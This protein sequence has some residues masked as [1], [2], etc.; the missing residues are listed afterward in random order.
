MT[1][2]LA[3]AAIWLNTVANALGR[4]LLAPVGAL[5][6]WLSAT[7]ASAGTGVLLLVLFKYTSNQQAIKR[8]RNDINAHM[9]ALKLFKDSALVSLKAQGRIL[10]GA[11]CLLV[12]AIVPILVMALPLTLLVAQLALWYQARPLRIGE[13]TIVALNLGGVPESPR[14]LVSLRPIDSVDVVA[15]PVRAQSRRE[16]FWNVRPRKPGTHRLEFQVG[17]EV[18]AKE[19]TV[20]EG[21]M[22]VSRVRPGWDWSSILRNPWESPFHLEDPIQSIEIDYPGRSSWIYGTNMWVIYWFVASMIAALC[23]RGV[24]KVAV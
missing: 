14:P 6:G 17:N 23:F 11:F 2:V 18:H 8:V 24:M 12:L 1:D 15:G 5:P 13:D 20:G 3:Q 10:M 21:F 9:L 22:R 19:I 16:V 4:F 7:S